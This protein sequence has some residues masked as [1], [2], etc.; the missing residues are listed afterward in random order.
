MRAGR[1]GAVS[2]A[3]RGDTPQRRDSDGAQTCPVIV[4]TYAKSGVE[5][6]QRMLSGQAVLACTSGTG[7]LPLCDMA[8]ATWREVDN[9][10]GPLS[11]MAV[12]SIHAMASSMITTIL[13]GAGGSR[14]CEVAFGRTSGAETF[15]ELYPATKFLC[16]H[17]SC[18][19]VIRAGAQANPWGLAGS[20]FGP[21]ATTHPGSSAAAI[22]AYWAARTEPLLQFE[23]AHP[24]A[25]RRVRYEDLVDH[26]DQVA[27]QIFAFL[28]LGQDDP[29]T[30][31]WAPDDTL[32]TAEE[33]DAPGGSQVPVDQIPPPL[34]SRINELLTRIGYPPMA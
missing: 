27:D 6:L 20:A 13:A 28:G 33:T 21:F 31:R 19:D 16:L 7:L 34:R 3:P 17:R 22:A 11:R 9:R 1:L 32:P 14:W 23:E 12:A 10:D 2:A 5:Y 25:C 18:P 15:L 24:G 8:A 26:P 30:P 4:L 29:I